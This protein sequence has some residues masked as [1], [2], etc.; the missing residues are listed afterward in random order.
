MQ[1]QL[2]VKDPDAGKD[3]EQEEKGEAKYDTVGWQLNEH[4]FEQTLEGSKGQGNLMCCHAAVHGVADSQTYWAT[5]QQYL[6]TLKRIQPS[7][8]K[9][10]YIY[11]KDKV[12]MIIIG[13][14]EV[15]TSF[16]QTIFLRSLI[17][18]VS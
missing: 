15:R 12:W 7:T 14:S 6:N 10:I 18:V 17:Y 9:S 2:A 16:G 4:E 8:K 5:E 11:W 3:W 13:T 1:R